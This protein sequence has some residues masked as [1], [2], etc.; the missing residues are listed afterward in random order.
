[1]GMFS[2]KFNEDEMYAVLAGGLRPGEQIV[3]AVYATFQ[4]TSFLAGRQTK[5]GYLAL[6]D[7][8]RLIGVQ[9]GMVS[10]VPFSAELGFL[11]KLKCKKGLL[12]A[13]T[14]EL[15]N[16]EIALKAV[17]SGKIV[18]AKFPHQQESLQRIAA[19][20]EAKQAML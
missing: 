10:T 8:N 3:A 11:R 19:E 5:P 6:T 17:A 15:D 2:M 14:V 7:G 1:M 9:S 20:L 16:G 18:G 4:S 13:Y 12:G